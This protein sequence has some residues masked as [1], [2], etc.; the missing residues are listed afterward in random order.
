MIPV[1]L[2]S[3]FR[4]TSTTTT[5]SLAGL[6]LCLCLVQPHVPT[7]D[8]AHLIGTFHP[9]D[10]FKFIVKF[11][12]QQTEKHALRDSLGYI[13]GNIT[14][15]DA[16]PVP[17]Q[18]VLLDKDRF[19]DYYQNRTIYDKDVACQIMFRG[20]NRFAYDAKCNPRATGDYL[21]KIPCPEGELCEDEDA[22]SN[23]IAGHQFTYATSDITEP[24]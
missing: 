2:R 12:F 20:I 8:A 17:V 3:C 24:R 22:A 23:V 9:N 14:A 10:F 7:I 1:P 4:P 16:Y 19:L 5:T 15:R 6:I 11:G 21:R 18:M 13:Y